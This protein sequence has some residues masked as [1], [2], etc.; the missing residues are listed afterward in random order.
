[1]YFN[2]Y[3]I[4][5]KMTL[6]VFGIFPTKAGPVRWNLAPGFVGKSPFRPGFV[7]FWPGL[8]GKQPLLENG[9]VQGPGVGF[10]AQGLGFA[11]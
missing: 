2:F 10:R 8:R 6:S 1:M 5:E 7:G 3:F 11:S 4:R 9:R